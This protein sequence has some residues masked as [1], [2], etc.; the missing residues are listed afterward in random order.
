M[1]TPA[2]ARRPGGAK[3]RARELALQGLYQ[4]FL[5]PGATPR[6]QDLLQDEGAH[7]PDATFLDR[8]LKGA[9]E[10]QDELAALLAPH[11][12]RDF[13]AVDPVE[14]AAL[15]LGTFELAHVPE[16]P[17]RVVINEYLELTKTFGAEQSHR[18][19][20]GVL[21]KLARQLRPHG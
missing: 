6:A 11:L 19:V 8:L 14:R 15:L 20:N 1:N 9:S 16:T 3:H 18:F 7:R 4:H 17:F 13:S 5:N 12:T 2:A 21:D 10:R